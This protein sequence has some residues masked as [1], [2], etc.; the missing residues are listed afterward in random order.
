MFARTFVHF[1]I[2]CA[3]DCILTMD[4]DNSSPMAMDEAE[5][6]GGD[7]HWALVESAHRRLKES[8]RFCTATG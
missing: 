7:A 1:N 2:S 4:S 3:S 5:R 6:S 8:G